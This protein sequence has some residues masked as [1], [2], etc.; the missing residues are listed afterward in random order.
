MSWG[1]IYNTSWWGVALDTARTVKARPDF[2][3]S[4]LNLLTSEQPNLVVNG[5]FDTVSDWI[6]GTGWSISGGKAVRVASSST[7][8]VQ[9]SVFPNLTSIFKITF[10]VV[11]SAGAVR[12]RAGTFN[13]PYVNATDTYTYYVTP[14]SN[15]QI[16]F[17]ADSSFVWLNRQR[18]GTSRKSRIRP[19]RSKE[20]FSR[21]DTYNCIKRLKQLIKWQ[22]YFTLI[23]SKQM[24]VFFI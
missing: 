16:K 17:Q 10:D 6:L 8:L 23:E 15:D 13:L 19:N 22:K 12:L 20:M 2:F 24:E 1:E 11:R 14:T 21:L 18:I 3:G 9:A 7:D 5:T 4:Q